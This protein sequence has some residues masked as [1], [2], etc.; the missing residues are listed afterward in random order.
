MP[1][2]SSFARFAIVDAE[3]GAVIVAEIKL[4]QIAVQVLLAAVLVDA[5]HSTLEHREVAF[6][7]I[8]RDVA[9]HVFFGRVL[10]GFVT[11]QNIVWPRRRGCFRLYARVSRCDVIAH[12]L[13]TVS[14]RQPPRW[15]VRTG[16]RA[17]QAPRRR[18][19]CGL[20]VLVLAAPYA[21]KRAALDRRLPK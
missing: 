1:F 11:P 15:N 4:R 6:D 12:D 14:C 9:A 21:A 19:C 18:G 13:V 16:R 20:A 8:G 10:D 2:A 17:R 3:R 7:R 5:A